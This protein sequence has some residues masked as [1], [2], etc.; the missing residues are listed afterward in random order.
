MRLFRSLANK[1][2]SRAARPPARC[3]HG[4]RAGGTHLRQSPGYKDTR[5]SVR[6]QGADVG[7]G[8]AL[9][10][11]S[12]ES[13]PHPQH[14]SLQFGS[15]PPEGTDHSSSLRCFSSPPEGSDHSFSLR[16]C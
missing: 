9:K 11:L 3:H 13:L 12:D 14:L 8:G 4:N 1:T 16:H 6:S 15:S 10:P 5:H 2:P 7:V